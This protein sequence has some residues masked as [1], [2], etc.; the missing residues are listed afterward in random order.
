MIEKARRRGP[1]GRKRPVLGWVLMAA[2]ALGGLSESCR[3]AELPGPPRPA[4]LF[5]LLASV[6]TLSDAAMADEKA[7]GL[8]PPVI[9]NDPTG[10]QRVQLWD[11]FN[12]SPQQ[13]APATTPT[14]NTGQ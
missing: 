6:T 8:H 14:I 10:R 12:T 2:L 7:T 3:A 1:R 13:L 4:G 11:E 9:L 5:E